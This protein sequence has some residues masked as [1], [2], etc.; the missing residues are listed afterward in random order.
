MELRI[1]TANDAEAYQ[2][3]RCEMLRDFP[4]AFGQ[5]I[6]T[7][8]SKSLDEIR[9]QL[10]RVPGGGFTMGAWSEEELVGTAGIYR[11][12]EPKFKHGAVLVAMYVRPTVQGHGLGRRLVEA[13][14]E[15]SQNLEGVERVSLTVSMCQQAAYRLYQ[16]IG[17]EEW[18]I[19]RRAL[20]LDGTF[21]DFAHMTYWLTRSGG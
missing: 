18:G 16:S 6:S 14:L 7:F 17:F 5:D 8:E 13:A 2:S 1:L 10:T 15:E 4:L 19:E 21:V 9:Q 12:T 3:I 20:Q 11:P